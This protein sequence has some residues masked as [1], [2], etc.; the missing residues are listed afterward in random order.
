MHHCNLSDVGG[1][2]WETDVLPP[3][4][5]SMTMDSK[6]INLDVAQDKAI[7][8]KSSTMMNWSTLRSRAK[9]FPLSDVALD[10]RGEITRLAFVR[11]GGRDGAMDFLNT[12]HA[13][14]ECRPLDLAT[15]SSLGFSRVRDEI[16]RLGLLRP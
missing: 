10:R 12:F 2:G 4:R 14:L 5:W 7:A 11:L 6:Q 15:S 13:G 1:C 8:N 3:T 16:E 9:A